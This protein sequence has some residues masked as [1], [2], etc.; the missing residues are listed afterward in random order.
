MKTFQEFVSICEAY[1]AAFMSGAQVRKTGEGGRIGANRKKTAPEMRRKSQETDAQGNRKP[2]QLKDRKDIGS[3]RQA[4]TRIQEPEQERGSA[5]V[6]AK[7]AAAAKA[8]RIAAARKR[9]AAKSSGE[10]SSSAKPKAKEVAQQAS[11]LLSKKKSTEVDLRPADQ[12][13]R[14]VVGMSKQKRK[15]ITRAG[16][17][18]AQE[19]ARQGEAKKQGKRP[20]DIVLKKLTNA[21]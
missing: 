18:F 20:E 19:L 9:A 1:D 5:D 17:R 3:Q 2:I 21:K 14:A 8:E 15:E 10:T 11:K 7:A 4:S 16:H 6:R 12:P 13:K